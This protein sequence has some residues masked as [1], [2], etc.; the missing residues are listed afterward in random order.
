[1][2]EIYAAYQ[3]GNRNPEQTL[4]WRFKQN[5]PGVKLNQS[6]LRF[7]DYHIVYMP[8][9]DCEPTPIND[10]LTDMGLEGFFLEGGR[11]I[12]AHA[13]DRFIADNRY[14]NQNSFV[15]GPRSSAQNE[16]PLGN[17]IKPSP[18]NS[19]CDSDTNC[20][21]ENTHLNK[22]RLEPESATPV[23]LPDTAQHQYDRGVEAYGRGA[24]DQALMHY[25]RAVQIDPANPAFKKKFADVLYTQHHQTE[26]ALRLYLQ[27]LEKNPKDVETLLSVCQICIDQK[28]WQDAAEICHLALQLQP[29]NPQARHNL[30]ILSAR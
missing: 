10:A 2:Q 15:H 3:A 9:R 11:H 16:Q 23:S 12:D 8:P 19:P 30:S 14:E 18:F 13:V 4:R 5:L 22:Q 7:K 1:M 21:K 6:L 24:K 17:A 25:A 28:R 29:N 27:I 20:R 26:E